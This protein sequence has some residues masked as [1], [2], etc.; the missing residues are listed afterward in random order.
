MKKGTLFS[1]ESTASGETGRN[2]GR[3]E[4]LVPSVYLGGPGLTLVASKLLQG[5][6][7]LALMYNCLV[8]CPWVHC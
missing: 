4:A 6:Q 2:Q 8:C 3:P 7:T 1:V 5:S